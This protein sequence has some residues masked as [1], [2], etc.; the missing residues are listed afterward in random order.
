MVYSGYYSFFYSFGVDD[1]CDYTLL[2]LSKTI[3]CFRPRRAKSKP[4]SKLKPLKTIPFGAVHSYFTYRISSNNS[5]GRLFEGRRLYEGSEIISNIA[6]WKSCP[7]YFV[8]FSHWI[9]K[10]I[11]S[12]KLNMGFLSVPNSVPWLIFIAWIV[13]DQFYWI[14][15][16]LHLTERG[17]RKR[18]WREETGREAIILNTSVKGGA[19]NRGTAIINSRKYVI[20]Q[21]K[22]RRKIAR[23]AHY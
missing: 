15:L 1:K 13:T 17:K 5:R 16:H 9:K 11:T 12:N 7:K 14:T 22:K 2:P 23:L 10:I 4:V 6:H 19:I 3:T 21:L 18:R 20:C 8:L